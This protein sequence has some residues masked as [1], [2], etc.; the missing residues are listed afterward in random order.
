MLID[1]REAVVAGVGE[2]VLQWSGKS[3]KHAQLSTF[4]H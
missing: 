4:N 1:C 2:T 3:V